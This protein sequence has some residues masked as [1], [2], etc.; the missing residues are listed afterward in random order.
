M[1]GRTRGRAGGLQGVLPVGRG[2][3]LA[4]EPVRS[5]HVEPHLR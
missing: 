2:S 5:G 1:V 4:P 3:L